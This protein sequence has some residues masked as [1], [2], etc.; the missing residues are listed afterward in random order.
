MAL[1]VIVRE[2]SRGRKGILLYQKMTPQLPFRDRKPAVVYLEPRMFG[3]RFPL[4]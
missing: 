3:A 1:E 4:V 2:T